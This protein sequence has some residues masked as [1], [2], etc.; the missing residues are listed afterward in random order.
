LESISSALAEGTVWEKVGTI[1]YLTLIFEIGF[2]ENSDD[3][4]LFL[5]ET[6]VISVHP[7]DI[8]GG[9]EFA[10]KRSAVCCT[11]GLGCGMWAIL[12]LRSL[13]FT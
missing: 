3:V 5:F 2:W 12:Y 6:D 4:S 9:S 11:G 10:K 8:S 1:G 13:K 7:N